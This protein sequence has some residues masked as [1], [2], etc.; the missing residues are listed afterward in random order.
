MAR[1]ERR[2]RNLEA[3]LTDCS[4][5]VPHTQ[6]WWDYW[7]AMTNKLFAGEKLDELIPLEFV[8][9]LM[10]K[11]DT[12]DQSR[13][14]PVAQSHQTQRADKNE[15]ATTMKKIANRLKSLKRHSLRCKRGKPL[16]ASNRCGLGVQF[17][18]TYSICG[19]GCRA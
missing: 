10:A 17:V 9:A 5:L 13:G 4:G 6:A 14:E 18:R 12:E 2:L 19:I 3:Q 8:H 1:L 11:A 15:G 16:G 7:L